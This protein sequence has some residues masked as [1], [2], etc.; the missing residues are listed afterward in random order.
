[1]RDGLGLKLDMEHEYHIKDKTFHVAERMTYKA[2]I[3]IANTMAMVLINKD[4]VTGVARENVLMR[5]PLMVFEM[6]DVLTDF[7]MEEYRELEDD[8]VLTFYED[9]IDFVRESDKLYG[10]FYKIEDA[11]TDV[12]IELKRQIKDGNSVGALL[13]SFGKYMDGDGTQKDVGLIRKMLTD[14]LIR[15]KKPEK[16]EKEAE[17]EKP[18]NN[19]IDLSMYRVKEDKKK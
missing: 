13:R 17:P 1:M 16:D 5:E 4:E 8:V 7:N 10:F 2:M 12:S 18:E 11:Y 14:F 6:F 15:A 9:V 19:V 3:L